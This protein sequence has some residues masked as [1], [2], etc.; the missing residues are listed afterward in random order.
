MNKFT[1]TLFSLDLLDV[2]VVYLDF[3]NIIKKAAKKTI[4]HNHQS[5][6]IPCWD[7]KCKFF[8]TAFLQSPQGDDL[9]LAAK[10]WRGCGHGWFLAHN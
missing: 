3:C 10:V 8:C 5:N 9:S 6:Y 1:K 4:P 2:D 7:A